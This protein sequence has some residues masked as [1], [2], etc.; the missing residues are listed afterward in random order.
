MTLGSTRPS[1]V[2]DPLVF[3][4]PPLSALGSSVKGAVCTRP[5]PG[6]RCGPSSRPRLPAPPRMSAGAA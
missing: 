3:A 1:V 4:V 6:Y 2:P 5:L